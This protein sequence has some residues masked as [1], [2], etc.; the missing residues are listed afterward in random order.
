MLREL[1]PEQLWVTEMPLRFYGVEVGTRMTVC[2]LSDEGLRSVSLSHTRERTRPPRP[3]TLQ[4]KL[5]A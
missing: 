2:R 3:S 1:S 5:L 4:N